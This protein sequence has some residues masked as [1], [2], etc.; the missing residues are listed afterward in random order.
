MHVNPSTV[1]IGLC[2]G[3]YGTNGTTLKLLP[4]ECVTLDMF[5]QQDG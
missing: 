4:P 3:H 1:A 5:D 2:T